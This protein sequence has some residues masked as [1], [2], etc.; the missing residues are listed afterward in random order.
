MTGVTNWEA[1]SVSLTPLQLVVVVAV[2]ILT[3]DWMLGTLIALVLSFFIGVGLMPTNPVGGM[4]ALAAGSAAGAAAFC[5]PPLQAAGLIPVGGMLVLAMGIA[6]LAA[7]T[8]KEEMLDE[9]SFWCR[10]CKSTPLG[11]GMVT[12]LMLHTRQEE[13]LAP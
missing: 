10:L 6:S 5:F 9:S 2:G 8:A 12:V 1:V 4:I 13:D 11:I 7:V 3:G